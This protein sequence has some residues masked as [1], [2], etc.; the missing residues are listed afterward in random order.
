[1][2]QE[3]KALK[4]IVGASSPAQTVNA[5]RMVSEITRPVAKR[6][7]KTTRG[8]SLVLPHERFRDSLNA[9]GGSSPIGDLHAILLGV[10]VWAAG[11]WALATAPIVHP[12]S[13]ETLETLA[14]P[15]KFGTGIVDD[16]SAQSVTGGISSG[17]L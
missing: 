8:V 16:D 10:L 6:S 3:V 17:P 1:M 4:G 5:Q 14:T 2:H 11:V 7:R 9:I 15:T 12:A 13:A